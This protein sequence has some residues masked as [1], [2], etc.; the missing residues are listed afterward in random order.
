MNRMRPRKIKIL[1][2]G[3]YL[4]S[5]T[6]TASQLDKQL[7]CSPGWVAKK[8]GVD[9]RHFV[10]DE[11]ASYMGAEAALQAIEAA[12]L[13]IK[14]ID[15]LVCTN[16]VGEQPIPSNAVLVQKQLKLGQYGIP[17]FDI[18]STC[19]SFLTGLDTMSYLI[20]A[21]RYR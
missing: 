20:E 7:G 13:T 18:N 11:S 9:V 15:C 16:A 14:D 19:L 3:K 1:G 21:G 4:P 6:I 10:T 5:H 12:G 2:T 17:A 8:S